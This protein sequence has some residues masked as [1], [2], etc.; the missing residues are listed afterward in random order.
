MLGKASF[1]FHVGD[2]FRASSLRLIQVSNEAERFCF[3]QISK[4]APAVMLA[5]FM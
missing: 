2:V 1:L 4:K 5:P 3:L